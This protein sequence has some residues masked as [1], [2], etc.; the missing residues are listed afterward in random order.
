MTLL[1]AFRRRLQHAHDTGGWNCPIDE[2]RKANDTF[3]EAI[4]KAKYR[5]D[6]KNNAHTALRRLTTRVNREFDRI[7]L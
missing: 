5:N 7:D 2:L 6:E 3:G 4:L 1:Q